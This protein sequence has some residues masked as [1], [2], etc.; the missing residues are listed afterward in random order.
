MTLRWRWNRLLRIAGVVV[1]A[2][3]VGLS[4]FVQIQ[5]RILRWRAERLLAD[6][7]ELQSH[8]S[9]W[10]DAQK[11]M[12][13]WGAWG[14]YEGACTAEECTGYI[15]IE[16]SLNTFI[17]SHY[18]QIPLL[19]LLY[20][21]FSLIGE[22]WA[23]VYATLRI[24][25]G[26]VE[27][28]RYELRV[29]VFYGNSRVSTGGY[30]LIGITSQ[31]AYGF[32]PN[33]RVDRLLH[34]EYWIGVT[35]GCEGC[36][37]FMTQFTPLAEREKISELTDFN[38]SCI[39]RWFSC[40]SEADIMPPAWRQYQKELPSRQARIDAFNQCKVPLEFFGREE[41]NIAV[42]DVISRQ[43]TRAPDSVEIT[44]RLRVARILKGGIDWPLNKAEDA[45]VYD[46]GQEIQGW[47]STDMVAGR[48]YILLAEIG[49]DESGKKEVALNN[50][51]VIP[52]N[53]QNLG[54]IQRGID[55]SLARH[56]PEK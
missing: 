31:S 29:S 18:K 43:A 27:E 54:A 50:C 25:S 23:S 34:P 15:E 8:K 17:Y 2:L 9:T 39:T 11:I 13:K 32:G 56:I 16:D 49:K 44:A 7:R 22:K 37:K 41:E 30:D 42:A 47:S 26:V 46:R 14:S 51:G 12:T 28:S 1:L 24:K 35:G 4:I 19:H 53:E 33:F 55:A 6:M 38:F 21:P 20:Y 5:Q 40:T 36:I 48:R 3:V 45:M 52:Y 10:A